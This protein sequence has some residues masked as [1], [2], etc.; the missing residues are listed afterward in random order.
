MLGV[1]PWTKYR[2]FAMTGVYELELEP[3]VEDWLG[4][5]SAKHYT[6]VMAAADLLAEHEGVLGEPYAKHLQGKVRELRFY[7]DTT[8]WRITYWIG[9]GR[10]IILLTVFRKTKD[11]EQAQV[12]RAVVAQVRCETKHPPAEHVYDRK[13]TIEPEESK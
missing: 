9:P 2:I 12:E 3:E 13:V 4:E 10:R 7:L 11:R 5:L 1:A 8:A 6:R